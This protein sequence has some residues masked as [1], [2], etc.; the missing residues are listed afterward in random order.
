LV[1]AV[2]SPHEPST[3]SA[4][5]EREGF[6]GC[7]LSRNPRLLATSRLYTLFPIAACGCAVSPKAVLIC[8]ANV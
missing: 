4:L 5:A 7:P 3:C 8:G 1:L 6:W 2:A